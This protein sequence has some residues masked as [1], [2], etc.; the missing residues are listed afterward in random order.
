MKANAT[1]HITSQNFYGATV[2]YDNTLTIPTSW[3]F[4]SQNGELTFVVPTNNNGIPVAINVNDVCGN[5]YLLYAMP[6]N[7]LYLEISNGND[8]ITVTLQEEGDDLSRSQTIDQPWSIEVC[9]AAS[10]IVM[11]TRSSTSRSV[12]IPT[13]VWPKGLYIVKAT[14]GKEELTEKIIVK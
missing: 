14:V 8:N 9:N 6:V 4:S 2:S 1:T 7:Y 12:S 13:S 11:A 10:G 3:T 5:Y